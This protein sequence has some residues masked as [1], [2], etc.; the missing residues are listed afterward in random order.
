[1]NKRKLVIGLASA[2]AL[3]AG[4]S[5]AVMPASAEMRHLTVTL[6]SGRVMEVD[7][8]VPPGTPLDQVVIPG[9]DEPVVSVVDSGPATGAPTPE[10]TDET[11]AEEP[12][13]SDAPVAQGGD[14]QST[15]GA[16][17]RD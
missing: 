16:E 9:V 14:D 6:L 4:F 1:M 7:V 13:P 5:A 15:S 2:G 12:K 17:Q 11:P 3:S 8:D 10:K